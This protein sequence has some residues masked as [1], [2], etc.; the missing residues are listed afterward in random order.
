LK[1]QLLQMSDI[2]VSSY[3]RKNNKFVINLKRISCGS[4]V[5]NEAQPL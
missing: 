2:M 5:S 1:T 3:S 4:G